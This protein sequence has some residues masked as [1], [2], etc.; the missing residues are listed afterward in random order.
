MQADT[1]LLGAL[2]TSF[3]LCCSVC[4]ICTSACEKKAAALQPSRDSKHDGKPLNFLPVCAY[5]LCDLQAQGTAAEQQ[6][7]QQLQQRYSPQAVQAMMALSSSSSNSSRRAFGNEA[8]VVAEA[9]GSSS[10]SSSR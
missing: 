2:S 9:P 3:W 5:L 10:N 1:G 6:V 4:V 7:L 8:A